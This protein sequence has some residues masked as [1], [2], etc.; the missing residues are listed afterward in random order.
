MPDKMELGERIKQFR[1]DQSLTLKDVEKRAKVSATHVSEIERGMT[2]PTVGALEKIA[3]ALGTEPEYFLQRDPSPDVSVVRRGERRSLVDEAW[4]ATLN[5]LCTGVRVSEISLL[6]ITLKPGFDANRPADLHAEIFVHVRDGE[7]EITIDNVI[8][9]LGAGDNLH[10]RGDI[11]YTVRNILD[12]TA[13]FIWVTLP[14][15]GI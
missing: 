15:L 8:Y 3:N 5:R 13:R 6:E 11:N 14:P 9:P 7:I 4:G 2:S 1:L 10:F 12:K